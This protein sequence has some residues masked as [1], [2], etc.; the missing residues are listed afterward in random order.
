M[1][2]VRF[3]HSDQKLARCARTRVKLRNDARSDQGHSDTQL[4]IDLHPSATPSGAVVVPSEK[5]HGRW[6]HRRPVHN[7][8]PHS[9][10]HAL[11]SDAPQLGMQRDPGPCAPS[12]SP[13]ARPRLIDDLRGRGSGF[14]SARLET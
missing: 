14:L 9:M 5:F 10:R 4:N 3:R 1:V 13:S 12:L 6:T 8:P 7:V 2:A 11:D